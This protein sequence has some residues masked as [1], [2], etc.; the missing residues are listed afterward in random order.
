MKKFFLG[1]L[2]VLIS[3]L[4]L[5]SCSSTKNI[6]NGKNNLAKSDTIAIVGNDIIS[7]K[8]YEEFYIKNNGGPE[9]VP[10][11][12]NETKKQFLDLLIKYRMKVNEAY[13]QDYINDPEVKKEIEEYKRSLAIPYIIDHEVTEPNLKLWYDRRKTNLKVAAIL[14]RVNWNNPEDTLAKYQKMVSIIDSLNKGVSFGLLANHHSQFRGNPSDSGIL[15][16]VT[17]G[18]TVK[19]FENALY[20]LQIGQYTPKPVKLPVGYFIIK[21]LNKEPRSGGKKIAHIMLTFKNPTHDD[22]L[23]VIKKSEEL[24]KQ[25]KSGVDFDKLA[26]ENSEDNETKVK[27]GEVGTFEREPYLNPREFWDAAMSLKTGE[28]STPIRTS[29]GIHIIKN[30]STEPYPS[31][32]VSREKL[33]D[34][35]KSLQ[36]DGDYQNFIAVQ[37]SKL[38]H[39]FNLPILNQFY[40]YLDT[41]KTT[42]SPNWD[43][44]LTTDFKK[45]ALMSFG[46]NQISVNE[47]VEQFKNH[48]ELKGISL[49]PDGIQKGMNKSSEIFALQ[50]RA[51][52]IDSDYPEFKNVMKEYIDGLL[53]FKAEQ[54]AVWSK[55]IVSDSILKIYFNNNR[56]QFTFPDRVDISEIFVADDSIAQVVHKQLTEDPVPDKKAAKAKKGKKN[57]T[58]EKPSFEELAAKYTTREGFK[59]KK[60][61]WGLLSE[62]DNLLAQKGMTMSVGSISTPFS[63]ENGVSIIKVNSKDKARKKEF[64]ECGPELSSK[65]QE[66][67]TKRVESDWLETLKS[68]FKV[69]VFDN[70]INDAFKSNNK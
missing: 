14:L 4:I 36:Y 21:L 61:N 11:A 23:N 12:T 38:N 67:E 9:S 27:D 30:L 59:E 20:S 64:T 37:K 45:N 66:Y 52:R 34:D 5:V 1:N 42:N 33:K 44:L 43:S 16:Y 17:A 57:K 68:K 32:E 40:S 70:K 46:Q 48:P 24:Y 49:N 28:I 54:N 2:L 56:D 53:L 10:K 55:V 29:F 35:Y 39:S 7:L 25:L 6:D 8:D 51:N 15:G 62:S 41:T 18:Q 22:T 63:F 65:F 47:V 50:E 58:V 3:C 60:G 31:Y 19:G 69:L 26:R 13:A